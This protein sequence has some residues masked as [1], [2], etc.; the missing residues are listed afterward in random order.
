VKAA[1]GE[2]VTAEELGG[3]ELHSR[4]SGVTDH[5][6]DDDAHALQIVRVQSAV[7]IGRVICT[8][9]PAEARERDLRMLA[10]SRPPSRRMPFALPPLE[11]GPLVLENGGAP[12]MQPV[13]SHGRLDDLVGPRFLVIARRADLLDGSA[14]N[15][16][17]EKGAFVAAVPD[18]PDRFA[19]PLG[20]WMDGCDFDFALVRPDCYVL[21]AGSDLGAATRRAAAVLDPWSL[22]DNRPSRGLPTRRSSR[23][24]P[25]SSG[26]R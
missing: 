24:S 8:V 13:T 15:W 5:L 11:P 26:S 2:E 1:T 17:R 21:W 25:S 3:G 7:S 10:D 20:E 4:R 22:G 16:W 19:A 6:A 9:D 18:L 14:A 23:P 12:F